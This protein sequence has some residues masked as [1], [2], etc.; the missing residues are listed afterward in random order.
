[1]C[2]EGRCVPRC[3]G[4]LVECG[5]SACVD[6]WTDRMH[7]GD[8]DVDCGDGSDC[9]GGLCACG[10]GRFP[11]GSDC[12]D[13]S[14]DEGHCGS[15]GQSC[16]SDEFCVAGECRQFVPVMGCVACPCVGCDQRCCDVAGMPFAI[17]LDGSGCP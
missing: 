17:C 1:M 4:G 12:V 2:Q 11:C 7:C 14:A 13:L 8:C 16:G 6:T 15:C 5:G 9:V 3:D 10:G